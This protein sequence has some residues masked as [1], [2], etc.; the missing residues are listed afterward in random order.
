[1]NEEQLSDVKTT[2]HTPEGLFTKDSNEIVDGLLKD[3]NG[4]EELALKRIT[5]YINRAGDGLSNKT[6]VHAAKKALEKKVEEKKEALRN[7]EFYE[8]ASKVFTERQ[9]PLTAAG[10]S[11]Y[12]RPSTA[13]HAHKY[14]E[15]GHMNHPLPYNVSSDIVQFKD[16]K[17]ALDIFCAKNDIVPAIFKPSF[18][19]YFATDPDSMDTS[20]LAKVI[21]VDVF[22]S[23]VTPTIAIKVVEEYKHGEW[24]PAKNELV[25]Y[26]TTPEGIRMLI[27]EPSDNPDAIC[28]LN[29]E[30]LCRALTPKD[31]EIPFAQWKQ[32]VLQQIEDDNNIRNYNTLRYYEILQTI[33]KKYS[34]DVADIYKQKFLTALQNVPEFESVVEKVLSELDSEKDLNA[35]KQILNDFITKCE[36]NGLFTFSVKSQKDQLNKYK[37]FAAVK[38]TQNQ[39]NRSDKFVDLLQ[40]FLP[41]DRI[42][43]QHY[44]NKYPNVANLL[45]DLNDQILELEQG[46]ERNEK[47]NEIVNMLQ[48]LH[49][50]DNKQA[51]PEADE[52]WDQFNNQL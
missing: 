27:M 10:S 1:M 14:P 15:P 3:A 23:A 43:L 40:N 42:T 32:Q 34:S 18:K 37:D 12:I 46:P 36:Q 35:K 19:F 11:D 28:S 48:E 38:T 8:L 49:L 7:S 50:F 16:D 24:F 20:K 39:L 41:K 21:G 6:Q 5:Y 9:L 44:A 47:I 31:L 4:D 17:R 2:H 26:N 52:I 45:T 30:R 51:T 33:D 29:Y 22:S 13:V 25:T